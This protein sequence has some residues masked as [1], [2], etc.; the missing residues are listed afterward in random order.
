MT[1]NFID[2]ET[3]DSVCITQ[4]HAAEKTITQAFSCFLLPDTFYY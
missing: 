4:S 1:I 2:E 3:E